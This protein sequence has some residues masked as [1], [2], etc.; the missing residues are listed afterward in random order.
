[1][2]ALEAECVVDLTQGPAKTLL[3][4]SPDLVCQTFSIP[5]RQSSA[6]LIDLSTDPQSTSPFS[7]SLGKRKFQSLQVNN[8]TKNNVIIEDRLN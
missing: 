1:M 8:L 3:D 2:N 7:G 4:L 6:T 5:S